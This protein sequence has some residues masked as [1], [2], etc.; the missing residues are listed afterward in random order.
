[1]WVDA[2]RIRQTSAHLSTATE[3][4]EEGKLSSSRR[5]TRADNEVRNHGVHRA[6]FPS[7]SSSKT[8]KRSENDRKRKADDDE[9]DEE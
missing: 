1:M 3:R 9:E 8:K 4:D 6:R 2:Q 5:R 7:S